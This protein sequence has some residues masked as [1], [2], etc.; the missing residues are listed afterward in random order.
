MDRKIVLRSML[1][2]LEKLI[3]LETP[4]AG[5]YGPNAGPV[6]SI[7]H[8]TIIVEIKKHSDDKRVRNGTLIHVL[9]EAQQYIERIGIP[10][11]KD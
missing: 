6:T 8:R 7:R 2:P 1:W 11:E 4:E 10:W 9:A 3:E 5:P